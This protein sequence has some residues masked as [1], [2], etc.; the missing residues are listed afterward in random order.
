MPPRHPPPVPGGPLSLWEVRWVQ[1]RPGGS[2]SWPYSGAAASSKRRASEAT[3]GTFLWGTPEEGFGQGD[4][5]GDRVWQ[6]F[7]GGGRVG[8]SVW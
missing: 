1:G 7:G 5:A 4:R 6:G 8:D 2:D 3:L